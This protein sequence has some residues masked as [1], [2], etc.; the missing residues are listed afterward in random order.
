MSVRTHSF[1]TPAI[2]LASVGVAYLLFAW[3][4][5]PRIVDSQARQYIAERSG[6]RLTLERPDFNP[7]TLS[8]HVANLRLQEADGKPL[9][10]LRAFTLDLSAASLLR[11][12]FIFDAI[13]L[14]DAEATLVLKHD[15]QLNWS[16]LIEALKGKEKRDGSLPRLVIKSFILTG[17]RLD[18]ADQQTGFTTRISPLQLELS[19]I[20]TLPNDRDRYMISARTASGARMLWQG[21]SMLN[22]LGIAGSV[23]IENLDLAPF[24]PYIEGSLP[25]TSPSGV[26]SLAADLRVAYV[27]KRFDLLLENIAAKVTNFRLKAT[28]SS[29]PTIAVNTFEAKNGRF[30]LFGRQLALGTLALAGSTIELPR[31]GGAP[32]ELLQLGTLTFDHAQVDMG[33][34]SI[35]LGRIALRDGRLKAV[36]NAKGRIDVLDA[37]RAAAPPPNGIKQQART[38]A[39]PW[40][41]RAHELE[42]SGFSATFRDE[43]VVPAADLSLDGIALSVHGI[44]DDLSAPLPV[45]ASLQARG[46]GHLEAEGQVIPGEPSADLHIRLADLALKPAQPYITS[47]ARLTLLNG[48]LSTEGRATYGKRGGRYKGG[49]A[50]RDLRLVEAGTNNVFLAWKV[51]R[52]RNLDVTPAKL[53]IGRIDID[54]LDTKLIINKDKSANISDILQRPAAAGPSAS[55]PTAT[56][57]AAPGNRTPQFPVNIHSVRI[58]EGEMDFAD[59]SLVLPFA[60]HIH[61]LHGFINGLSSLPGVAGQIELDGQVDDYGIVRAIGQIDLFNPADV[62]DVKVMFGNVDMTRLTPYST[63]FAGRKIDSG[64]LSLNLEYKIKRRQLEGDNQIIIDRVTLGERVTSPEAMDLPLDLA[65]ALL[66]DSEGR[67]DLGLPV[68]GNLEDPQF[69][70]GAIIWKAI[71]NVF[72]MIATAPFRALGA[73]FGGGGQIESIHFDAGVAELSPPERENIVRL[74]GILNKRPGLFITVHGT[75]SEADRVALQDLQVRR[76]VAARAGLEVEG[77]D[78]PGP[79]STNSPKVQAALENLFSDRI[80]SAELDAMKEGFRKANP[81]QMEE[82]AVGKMMSRLSGLFRKKRTLDEREVS[83]LKGADFHAVLFLRLRDREPVSNMQMQSLAVARG[84]VTVTALKAANAPAARLALGPPEKADSDVKGVPVNLDLGNEPKPAASAP[85]PSHAS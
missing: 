34:R 48:R 22:P 85:V 63:T 54:R 12:A 47:V 14:D 84:E 39:L 51:L 59:H 43:T 76:A 17:G 75:Y 10:A 46:G 30:D 65:I 58:S 53:D 72:K 40:H 29:G 23:S 37:L 1:K 28:G 83:Q 70:F 61:K 19:D 62:T 81:G 13:R 33:R 74:A 18:F 7:F 26:A 69:S 2:V 73:L 80:G 60:T 55:A 79:L 24:R 35:T 44:S 38:A 4:A 49:F 6:H 21:Q 3:L 66:E 68:R 8:L 42:L 36:R 31:A 9:F 78:D 25:V 71:L 50:L 67:I 20:S 11:G 32:V 77:H 64:K 41:Y 16:A 52:S 82:G 57:R 5:L 45:R 27:G 56:A 15:G